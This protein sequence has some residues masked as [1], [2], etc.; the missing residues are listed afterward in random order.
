MSNGLNKAIIVGNLGA[1]P[2][3]KSV[4]DTTVTR[5]SVATTERRKAKDGDTYV[6]STEWHRIVA[7]GKQ[8]EAVFNHLK[9]GSQVA[10]T[11]R[12]KTRK[13]TD[14]DNIERYAT[15]IVAEEVTF[16]GAK[17]PSQDAPRD[18]SPTPVES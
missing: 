15:D 6:E 14:K 8:G 2:E 4:G 17:V 12:I 10:I 9:K 18:D 11:G 16:L 7:W 1:D 13:Y 5:F 3:Q